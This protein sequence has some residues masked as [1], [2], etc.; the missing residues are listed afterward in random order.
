MHL[1]DQFPPIWQVSHRVRA[2]AI[3][4]EQT[5][6]EENYH[7]CTL[8]DHRIP[9][10]VVTNDAGWL[11]VEFDRNEWR[12]QSAQRRS[13]ERQSLDRIRILELR[14]PHFACLQKLP[15]HHKDPFDRL[16]IAQA[17][18]ENLTLVGSDRF[19]AKYDVRSVWE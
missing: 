10:T 6:I 7:D 8:S 4:A 18:A 5:R 17:I 12:N 11:A 14:V 3:S 2:I 19:F 9:T 1:Y 13:D 15:W 16:L